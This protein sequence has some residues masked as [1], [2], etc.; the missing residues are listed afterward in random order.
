[1][2]D[3]QIKRTQLETLIRGIVRKLINEYEVTMSTSDL[4]QMAD[5]DPNMDTSTPPEDD[6][7]PVEKA[8][9]E[10]DA[11]KQKRQDIKQKEIELD[12]KKK[13]MEFNKKKMEQQ[14]RF[15]IPNINKDLQKLKGAKI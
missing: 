14:R 12:A 11:E 5:A 7:T 1:M 13:E 6:M 8:R 15:D 9:I 2:K 3:V 10:R 4:K